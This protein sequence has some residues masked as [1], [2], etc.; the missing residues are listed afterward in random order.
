MSAAKRKAVT[1]QKVGYVRVSSL[2][3]ATDRQLDGLTLDRVFT[4][5]ASGKDANRPRLQEAMRYCRDGDTL[6]VHSL[7]RL[8]R[9]VDDLRR[10]VTDLTARGV[11]VEFVKERLIF[12]TSS[13]DPMGRF[14][15]TVLGA[16]AEMERSLIRERQ[17]EGIAIAKRDHP[18]KYA[19]RARSLTP[20]QV[21]E[22]R[23]KAAEGTSKTQL[24]REFK[25]SR[26]TV[27][28]YL[29]S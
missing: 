6:V 2:D 13:Q 17:R 3:Q 28:S 8:A 16:F 26:Q 29:E 24:A 20:A 9:N 12:G 15:L 14:M 18:E 22:L 19:G 1:G 11:T 5:R 21:G 4:E 7:D 10:I 27:Y 23:D 25:V